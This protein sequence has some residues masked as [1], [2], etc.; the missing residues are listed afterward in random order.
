M[1][2]ANNTS[3]AKVH[4][5]Y[6][7]HLAIGLGFMFLFPQLS[8]I[9]PITEVGMHVLGV[10]IGMVYLWSAVDSIWPSLLGLMLIAM[11][12]YIPEQTGYAAVKTLFMNA[13]GSETVITVM[14]CMFLFA[15]VEYVGCTQYITRFFMTRKFLENQRMR[16]MQNGCFACCR[17]RNI[18]CIPAC[19]SGKRKMEQKMCV[20]FLKKRMWSFIR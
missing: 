3:T 9:E 12:G 7:L 16:K 15:A 4:W 1:S 19:V 11:C 10:F 2:T 17:T 20:A 5:T 18:R 8:P 13:F 14:L 6:W